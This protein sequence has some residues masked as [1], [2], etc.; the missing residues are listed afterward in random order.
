MVN[1]E[2]SRMRIRT[3]REITV[4]WDG[5]V[6]SSN[7]FLYVP[8]NREH[9]MLGHLDQG[10][11]FDRY[12]MDGPTSEQLLEWWY[13]E[14]IT[15]NNQSVGAILMSFVQWMTAPPTPDA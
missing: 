15:R 14:D 5:T 7:G 10:H 2:E 3:N 4:D 6:M 1:L 11:C 12:V 13:P 8:D 9:Y